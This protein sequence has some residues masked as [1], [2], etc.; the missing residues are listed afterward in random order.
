MP[1][2]GGGGARIQAEVL[3]LLARSLVVETRI[4]AVVLLVLL[5]RIRVVAGIQA[6]RRTLQPAAARISL[7]LVTAPVMVRVTRIRRSGDNV[8]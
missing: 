4:Q 6:Q 7:L 2:P 5:A 3:I 1:H 8:I